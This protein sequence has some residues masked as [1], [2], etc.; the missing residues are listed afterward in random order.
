MADQMILD[1]DAE[2]WR[3]IPGWPEYEISNLARVRRAQP[4]W[5]INR[6]SGKRYIQRPAGFILSTFDKGNGYL[7]VS[8]SRDGIGIPTGVH[9]L[10]CSAFCPPA[11]TPEHCLVAHGDG[12]PMNNTPDNLRW[13]THKDNQ[14][15]MVRHGR[16]QRGERYTRA[17]LREADARA[18]KVAIAAG[19]NMAALARQ[20]GVSRSTVKQIKYGN[21]WGWLDTGIHI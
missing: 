9:V 3:V 20:Y 11:P 21:N 16:S 19:A 7:Y 1:F 15:D 17:V 10:V 14:Q 4:A 12:N 6:H 5:R 2:E 18:I 13:A 8:L